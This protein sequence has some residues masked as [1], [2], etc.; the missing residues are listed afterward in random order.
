[1]DSTAAAEQYK[2]YDIFVYSATYCPF[3]TRAKT[4]AQ[5]ASSNV[6]IYELDTEADGD[7]V[8][9]I[10]S[11]KFNHHTVPMVFVKGEFIGGNS[12]LQALKSSGSLAS[13]L[14]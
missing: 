12:E 6:G 11:S 2:D 4:T 5:N 10:L 14:A 13:K 3:C 7:S 8:R 9:S 1:M